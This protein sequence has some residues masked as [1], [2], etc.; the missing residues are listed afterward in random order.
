MNSNGSFGSNPL[1]QELELGNALA[2][3]GVMQRVVTRT[4]RAGV[5]TQLRARPDS[6]SPFVSS[7]SR[8]DR[9]YPG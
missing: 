8:K 1:R 2:L 4:Y 6:S 3:L 9:D 7:R 5:L